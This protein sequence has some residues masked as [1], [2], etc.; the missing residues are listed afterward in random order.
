M[1]K[2]SSIYTTEKGA[3]ALSVI[4]YYI[5]LYYTI[6]ILRSGYIMSN[7]SFSTRDNFYTTN[8]YSAE[9]VFKE[10][11]ENGVGGSDSGLRSEFESFKEA[12]TTNMAEK[13]TK[14]EVRLKSVKLEPEDMSAETLGLVTG[15]GTVNVLSIPQDDSVTYEKINFLSTSRTNLLDKTKLVEGYLSAAG[16]FTASTAAQVT[17]FMPVENGKT[18]SSQASTTGTWGSAVYDVNKT[19]IRKFDMTKSITITDA[20]AKYIRVV[21]YPKKTLDFDLM[22]V[23]GS[24]YPDEYIPYRVNVEV[25]DNDFKRLL[26]EQSFKEEYVNLV[27]RTGYTKASTGIDE[28]T[29]LEV[30]RTAKVSWYLPVEYGKIYYGN[31]INYQFGACYDANKNYL[32]SI[33]DGIKTLGASASSPFYLSRS[34]VKYIRVSFENSNTSPYVAEG[35]KLPTA[36]IANETKVKFTSDSFKQWIKKDLDVNR[37]LSMLKWNV[38]GDSIT[39]APDKTR[40]YHSILRDNENLFVR[41]YGISGT[42]IAYQAGQTNEMSTRYTNMDNDADIVT[43]FGGINDMNNNITLGVMSDRVN[44]TFYGALHVLLVG[45]HKK[46]IGKRIGFI[47][48]INYGNTAHEPYHQAIREVCKYYSIPLLDLSKDGMINTVIAETNT[49]YFADGLHPNESGHDVIARK[50]RQFLLTL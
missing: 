36:I 3:L 42:R 13:A 32:C 48:P 33:A 50:V 14:E 15:T 23:E 47:S 31:F 26:L 6:L 45:L 7:D 19:F 5:I 34:D 44:T 22:F 9:A 49:A 39:A 30:T 2:V 16:A 18:Y 12:T 41:N 8:G 11:K 46:Y 20:N 40:S 21:Y 37:P 1:T 4:L 29:G 28:A 24:V 17:D 25:L 38:L 27:D 43:V 10:L 35:T